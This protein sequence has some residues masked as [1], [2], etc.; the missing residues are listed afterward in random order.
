MNALQELIQVEV[1]ALLAQV[2]LVENIK[3]KKVKA[4]VNLVGQAPIKIIQE[5]QLAKIQAQVIRQIVIDADKLNVQQE[6]ILVKV[7][8]I[9]KR[10][11]FDVY[12]TASERLV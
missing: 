11:S 2:A 4:A 9:G 3:T 6:N 12:K 8:A 1:S 5:R 10:D 7:I